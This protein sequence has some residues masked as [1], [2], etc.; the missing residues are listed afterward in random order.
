MTAYTDGAR[1]LLARTE[2][3]QEPLTAVL[4]TGQRTDATHCACPASSDCATEWS[5]SAAG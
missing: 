4:A 1:I 5:S 3:S 2:W